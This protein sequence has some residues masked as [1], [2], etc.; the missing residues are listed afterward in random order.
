MA[1]SPRDLDRQHAVSPPRHRILRQVV[2]VTIK[3]EGS[4]WRLQNELS[5]IQGERLEAIIDR[6][7]SEVGDP[8]RIHRLAS[9]EVDLG[10]ID[11]DNL[12]RDLVEK[13][14]PALRRALAARIYEEDAATAEQGEDPE[15]SS[16]LELVAFFARTGSLPW[17]ADASRARALDEALGFLLRRAASPLVALVRSLARDRQELRRLVLHG[18]DERLSGLFKALAAQGPRGL[19]ERSAE[20]HALLEARQAVAGVT[21]SELRVAVWVVALRAA[22]GGE[23][24]D[25][26][27]FWRGALAHMALELGLTYASLVAALHEQLGPRSAGAEDG[28]GA[29]VRS[30][31]REI[32]GEAPAED[33]RG[34]GDTGHSGRPGTAREAEDA[35]PS[36]RYEAAGEADDARPSRRYEAAGDEGNAR[37]AGGSEE[38]GDAGEHPRT[39]AAAADVG[40]MAALLDRIER[41]QS[42]PRALLA[43]LRSMA[44]RLGA[45]PS[46]PLLEALKELD[47]R[48]RELGPSAP[49]TA[50]GVLRLLGEVAASGS[51]SARRLQSSLE[52]LDRA[53]A[54]SLPHDV[55]AEARRLLREAIVGAAGAKPKRE[56][57]PER[58]RAPG[59]ERADA[60]AD[61]VGAAADAG[62][63]DVDAADDDVDADHGV[64]D[65]DDA[66][67]DHGI[68]AAAADDDDADT[69]HG[70]AHTGHGVADPDREVPDPDPV[71][72]DLDPVVADLD[73][74]VADPDH[75]VADPDP[76]VAD[77]D[78]VVADTDPGVADTDHRVADPDP[79]VADPNPVVADPNPVVADPN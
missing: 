5:R 78:H 22:G 9:L 74:A 67:A 25:A 65:I 3:D 71:V 12:E 57:A 4:A 15:T 49:E 48:A 54:A 11:I 68:A 30:L 75:A 76:V 29:V 37:E 72:A 56:R 32:G 16:Q 41:V 52:E 26:V 70:V 36:R 35:R 69:D 64:A 60:D 46:G 38:T 28:L 51:L 1:E 13:L 79:V 59:R 39:N 58:E 19:A 27:S 61:A 2:E 53:A 63:D 23:Q 8:D 7:C 40:A 14:A 33:A 17:W 44:R 24:A 47:H 42:L 43:E 10:P 21:A 66:D 6:V 55:L 50:R 77:L 62:P 18:E 31:V 34:A 73:H 20:L 45:R